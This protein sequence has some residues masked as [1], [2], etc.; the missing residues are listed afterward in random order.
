MP[1]HGNALDAHTEG[2]AGPGLGV[3]AHCGEDGRIDHP[4]PADLQPARMLADPATLATA[5]D[6]GEVVLDAGFGEGEEVR[7]ESYFH[8]WPHDLAGEFRQHALEVGQRDLAVDVE[9]LDL[10]EV[11]AVRRIRSVAPVTTPRTDDS[12]RR[13]LPLHDP[14]LHRAG[15]RA[16]AAAIGQIEGILDIARRMLRG[17][18]QRIEIMVDRLEV[19]PIGDHEPHASENGH[20]VIHHPG[21]WMQEAAV[22]P[23]AGQSHI[24]GLHHGLL[25]AQC[26]P[27]RLEGGF[28]LLLHAVGRAADL[29]PFLGRHRSHALEQSGDFALAAQKADVA[30]LDLGARGDHR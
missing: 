22:A 16:Q 12:H 10:V 2:I 9:P 3:V 23:A 26:R 28:N 13:R 1:N 4:R 15:L 8:V 14:N 18:I 30:L 29:R 11:H 27:R 25:A 6:A 24:D 5:H 7:A 17:R 19:R 21:H 20:G